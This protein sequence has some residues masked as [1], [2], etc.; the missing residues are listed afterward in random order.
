MHENTRQL[1]LSQYPE[2]LKNRRKIQYT[3]CELFRHEVPLQVDGR[4]CGNLVFLQ[5]NNAPHTK[6]GHLYEHHDEVTQV[7]FNSRYQCI[8]VDGAIYKEY[9]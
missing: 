9:V 6:Y 3:N 8:L 7:L 2:N 4:P 5:Q 1:I